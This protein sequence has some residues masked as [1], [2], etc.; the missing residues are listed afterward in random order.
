MAE[1]VYEGMFILDVAKFGRDPDGVAKS[2]DDIVTQFGGE[3][4]VARL[5]D[6]R[7]LA[8]PIDGH[9]K[10]AYWLTYFRLESTKISQLER[11]AQLN[12]NVLRT[13]VL[14]VDPRI[15]DTLIEHAA[16]GHRPPSEEGSSSGSEKP[17]EKTERAASDA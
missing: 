15:V 16:A 1:K 12:P 3:M 10:G 5:W 8:Y 14:S 7:R 17:A 2:I 13:L 11:A 4:V 6:E 9:R